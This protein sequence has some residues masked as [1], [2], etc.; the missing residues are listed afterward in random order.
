ME[1]RQ[2]PSPPPTTPATQ[3][4]VLEFLRGL[5]KFRRRDDKPFDQEAI[6][7]YLNRH[8]LGSLQGVARRIMMDILK[9]PTADAPWAA[10]AKRERKKEKPTPKPATVK[11]KKAVR[12]KKAPSRRRPKKKVSRKK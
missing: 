6:K 11:K 2:L 7:E 9:S 4:E 10:P 1:F 3:E 8:S 5:Q 12:K